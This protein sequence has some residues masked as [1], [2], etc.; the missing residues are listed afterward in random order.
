MSSSSTGSSMEGAVKEHC[1]PPMARVSW[2][3]PTEVME[4]P[5]FEPFAQCGS[6]V[7]MSSDPEQDFPHSLRRER[8]PGPNP[9]D[10]ATE[11]DRATFGRG[12]PRFRLETPVERQ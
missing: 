10:P 2:E 8:I 4:W 9:E 1:S 12:A 3:S 5:S 7:S 11:P 6:D